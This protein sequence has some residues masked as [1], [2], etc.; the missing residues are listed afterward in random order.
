[1][2][3]LVPALLLALGCTPAVTDYLEAHGVDEQG[4]AID[5]HLMARTAQQPSL[6]PQLGTVLATAAHASGPDQLRG[7]RLEWFPAT[8]APGTA[9]TSDAAGPVIFYVYEP[10]PGGTVGDVLARVGT[11]GPITFQ[12]SGK[13]LTGSLGALTVNYRDAAGAQ[14]AAYTF[15][16]GAVAATLP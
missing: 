14:H 1:V 4:T 6:Q 12:Q 15:S 13:R 2:A 11:G 9:Y 3:T 10:L 8:V 7:L 16:S 5:V